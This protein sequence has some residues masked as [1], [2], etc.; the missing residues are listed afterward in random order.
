MEVRD[1]ING[2]GVPGRALLRLG[3]A[4]SVKAFDSLR[5][6]QAGRPTEVLR[7]AYE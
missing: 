2:G 6:Y 4:L 5:L 7:A 3:E 1:F